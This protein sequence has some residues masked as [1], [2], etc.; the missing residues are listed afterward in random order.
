MVENSLALSSFLLLIFADFL[1][2]GGKKSA[3][4]ARG[5]GYLLVGATIM[6]F[7]FAPNPWW[8]LRVSAK[9]GA[10]GLAP[11]RDSIIVTLLLFIIFASSALLL[12]SVFLEIHIAK[13]KRGLGADDVVSSGTYRW[14]RHPGFWWFAILV[15]AIGVL[16]GFSGYFMTIFLLIAMDLLLIF[17]QDR[18]TFPKMFRGYDEY[19]KKVPFLFPRVGKRRFRGD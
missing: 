8:P 15:I 2:V 16:R 19:R 6:L 7:A 18:Y 1:W 9:V 12:W 5:L 3:A 4:T 14:C 11:G 13:R 10:Q 17:I